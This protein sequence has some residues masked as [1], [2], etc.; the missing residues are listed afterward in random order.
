MVQT[1]LEDF[2][3]NVH[4][5][6]LGSLNIPQK[7][8]L[9]EIIW[10]HDLPLETEHINFFNIPSSPESRILLNFMKASFPS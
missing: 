6:K 2:P 3:Q 4:Y 7:E 8:F 5:R 10:K 9:S 1:L